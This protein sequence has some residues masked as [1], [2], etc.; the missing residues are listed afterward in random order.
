MVERRTGTLS[1]SR[2]SKPLTLNNGGIMPKMNK[3]Q[4]EIYDLLEYLDGR[5]MVITD[6]DLLVEELKGA[7]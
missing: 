7:V 2:I 5:G 6:Y 1:Y 3:K 4:Q